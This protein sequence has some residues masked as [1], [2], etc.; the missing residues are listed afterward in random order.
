MKKKIFVSSL[1]LFFGLLFLAAGCGSS[2]TTDTTTT[3][4]S[5][6]TTTTLAGASALDAAKTGSIIASGGSF[7]GESVTAL[8]ASGGASGASLGSI[9]IMTGDGPPDSFFTVNL[10]A[11]EGD[12]VY[13]NVTGEAVSGNM[14][15]YMRQLTAAGLP[16][17]GAAIFSG[18]KIAKLGT[19]E[20]RD[21]FGGSPG[22]GMPAGMA[23]GINTFTNEVMA[24]L[25]A[26]QN[27]YNSSECFQSIT[28]LADYQVWV[29]NWMG[30]NNFLS[31]F[32]GATGITICT[33][34]PDL[35]TEGVGSMEIKMVFSKNVTG[36]IAIRIS[37]KSTTDS[38]PLAGTYSGI[39]T[40][41][42]PEG[43]MET[44]L[45][46]TFYG[47]NPASLEGISLTGVTTPD[48]F[49]ISCNM[50]PF[51]GIGSGRISGEAG[52]SLAT[53]EFTSS[54]G[55]FYPV[56]GTADSYSY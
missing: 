34:E 10:A 14:T 30:L 20:V 53:F 22:S 24:S 36:E 15:P 27:P 1:V 4:V 33:P 18:K 42:V 35:A 25:L 9:R 17:N 54:G 23:E 31:T 41:L 50:D 16:V 43:T 29:S 11:Q 47:T 21:M 55:T 51:T 48:G 32:T 13:I 5:A 8:S 40:L 56:G 45:A 38:G 19:F 28:T 44:T 52:T 49:T 46:M 12:D 2:T 7:M 3:T 26:G 39:G 37:T 6:T